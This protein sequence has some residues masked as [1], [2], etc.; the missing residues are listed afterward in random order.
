MQYSSKVLENAIHEIAKLPG[1]GRR[2]ALRLALHILRQSPEEMHLLSDAIRVLV[3]DVMYCKNCHNLSDSDI[4]GICADQNRDRETLCVVEDIRDVMAIEQTGQY[5]GLYHVLGGL[6]SPM[7]GIGPGE[8]TIQSLVSKIESGEIKEV[9]FA[10]SSN[11][12]GDTTTFYIF[13]RLN[14][15]DLTVSTIA[16][17][18]AV[19]DALEYADEITLGRSLQHRVPYENS[20]R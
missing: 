10:L 16:R 4:C 2:T 1:I 12:E 17:G 18:L 15:P 9:I 3:D 8:L 5:K 19:G 7:E 20:T 13:K 11:M 6:I 14:N